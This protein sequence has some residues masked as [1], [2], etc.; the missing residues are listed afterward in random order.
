MIKRVLKHLFSSNP[1]TVFKNIKDSIINFNIINV[2]SKEELDE[3][4]STATLSKKNLTDKHIL[5]FIGN[6]KP[7]E[8]YITR[9]YDVNLSINNP[10]SFLSHSKNNPQHL[11]TIAKEEKNSKVI[12]LGNAGLGKTYELEHLAQE[13]WDD[14]TD[15]RIPVYQKFKNFTTQNTIERFIYY[16]WKSVDNITFIFDGIDEIQDIQDFIS[17]LENF[18]TILEN[19]NKQFSIVISCRT[20]I[21]ESIV[22]TISG[23]KV[24][25]LKELIPSEGK[26]LLKKLCGPIIDDFDFNS[27]ISTFLRNPFQIEVLS[28]YINT[29]QK[30]PTN[31]AMLWENYIDKRLSIDTKYKQIRKGLN[32]TLI[33]SYCKKISL[34]NELRKSNVFTQDQLLKITNTNS[35]DLSQFMQNPLIDKIPDSDDWYFVHRNI[36]EYFAALMISELETDDIIDII[37][38]ENTGKTNPSLFNTISFLINIMD[39]TTTKFD[40]IIDWLIDHEPELLFKAE[41]DRIYTG[42]R[43]S[44]F[45]KYF[46]TQCKKKTLW[47]DTR[48][49]F[50]VPEISSFGSVPKNL[51]YLKNEIHDKTNHQ[52]ALISAINLLSYFIIPEN[53]IEEI[54]EFLIDCLRDPDYHIAIKASIVDCITIRKLAKNDDNYLDSIFEIFSKDTGNHINSSLL[55]LIEDYENIDRFFEFLHNEF[56]R[57]HKVMPRAFPEDI[58]RRNDYMLQGL[59]LKLESPENFLTITQH[60]FKKQPRI[61]LPNTDSFVQGFAE[62]CIKFIQIDSNFIIRFLSNIDNE[63]PLRRYRNLITTI[64]KSSQ[65]DQEV[66]LNLLDNFPFDKIRFFICYI[67]STDSLEIVSERIIQ[68]VPDESIEGFRNMINNRNDKELARRFEGL[69]KDNG[70][71]FKEK[72]WTE[73]DQLN[74]ERDLKNRIQSNFDILFRPEQL[75]EEIEEIFIENDII[76]MTFDIIHNLTD[77][78]YNENNNSGE[79]VTSLAIL[80][81]LCNVYELTQFDQIRNELKV[82]EFYRFNQ[83]MVLRER[84]NREKK[85]YTVSENQKLI[86][87]EWCKKTAKSIDLERLIIWKGS[88]KFQLH[89]DI[90]KLRVVFFFLDHF[91][92]DLE[93]SFLLECIP[94]YNMGIAYYGDQNFQ[95]LFDKINDK[96]LVDNKIIDNI[97]NKELSAFVLSWHIDYALEHS[98]EQT[99][100]QIRSYLT[101]LNDN[102]NRS[103]KLKLYIEKSLDS[104]ALIDCCT[105]IQSSICWSAVDLLTERKEEQALCTRLAREYLDSGDNIHTSNALRVLFYWKENDAIRQMINVVNKGLLRILADNNFTNYNVVENYDILEELYELFYVQPS[106]GFEGNFGK[107]FTETYIS[108]LSNNSDGYESVQEVLNRI[109]TEL[110]DS[111]DDLFYISL[112]IDI[113]KTSHVISKSK[114][115]NFRIARKKVEKLCD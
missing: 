23:F 73:E 54:K 50:S 99:Y 53:K 37:Q 46:D 97:L 79:L 55:S 89:P 16:K 61:S 108:N 24:F 21:Y 29:H 38:I 2:N 40:G 87:S 91:P 92:L 30:L 68:G 86:I 83:I 77:T 42:I 80:Q 27:N 4:L 13:I 88:S 103:E 48:N 94:F 115:Y 105:N 100:P 71:E 58:D 60:F 84:Y 7:Q 45:K 47:I 75:I 1:Y 109:K 43:E 67:I 41:G 66:I 10:Y 3:V 32:I 36:Q 95:N 81:D 5:K 70:V 113:S 25:Y 51:T 69:M 65:V 74:L 62:K 17:K 31:T 96:T 15:E 8:I 85:V 12:I 59:I 90:E 82:N 110:Q 93:Q 57:A 98:L 33:K 52:R 76:S 34:I 26:S 56:L 22:K 28:E 112:L 78:W 102:M 72:L 39:H 6:I 14:C 9:D 64:I 107:T 20:N 104:S 106:E 11:S 18:I 44:V 101:N 63:I 19:E 49:S 111:G 114:S 35:S